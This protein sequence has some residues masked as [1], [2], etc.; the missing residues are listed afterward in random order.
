M[1]RSYPLSV[2]C[3]SAA[4]LLLIFSCG[5]KEK[6]INIHPDVSVTKAPEV[7]TNFSDYAGKI[8]DHILCDADGSLSYC[9]YL[10]SNYNSEKKFPVIFIFDAHGVG[11]LPVEKYKS[12]AEEFGFI[13]IGSNN[14]K[15]GLQYDAIQH[16]AEVMILDV[17]KKF[18][19]DMTRRYTLGFSGG[20][21]V[22]GFI[23]AHE[24][25]FSGAIGCGAAFLDESMKAIPNF[26]AFGFAGNDDFN[27]IEMTRSHD[28]L[29][30]RKSTR[31]NSSHRT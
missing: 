9:L 23:A 4:L 11:H 5:H 14:A 18:P 15:N 3:F 28:A 13:L 21:R 27:L 29:K 2:I 24:P 17:E 7:K 22:A 25:N 16:I 8:K 10:P 30:D 31:L 6:K 1:K 19:L 26:F 12:L 20:S